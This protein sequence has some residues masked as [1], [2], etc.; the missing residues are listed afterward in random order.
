ME[1]NLDEATASMNRIKELA[2]ENIK[3]HPYAALGLAFGFGMAVGGGLITR[4]LVVRAVS[5]A[6]RLIAANIARNALGT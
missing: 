3:K 1:L 5:A 6:S 4:A 2:Q